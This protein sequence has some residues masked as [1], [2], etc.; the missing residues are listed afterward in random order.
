[1]LKL[2]VWARYSK[3]IQTPLVFLNFGKTF[4]TS[5]SANI[6]SAKSSKPRPKGKPSRKSS[7]RCTTTGEQP[8]I[9]SKLCQSSASTS[10]HE[11][12]RT[13]RLPLAEVVYFSGRVFLFN[14]KLITLVRTLLA[15]RCKAA[16][17]RFWPRRRKNRESNP[18]LLFAVVCGGEPSTFGCAVA[19]LDASS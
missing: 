16:G 8:D 7:E 5:L 2:Q 15:W 12:F 9:V 1:M 3:G 18:S 11:P 10:R 19:S 6:S 4:S 14:G 17:Q 13:I